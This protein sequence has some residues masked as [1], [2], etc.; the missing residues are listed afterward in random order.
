MADTL[1]IR[2]TSNDP[3][4]AR[5]LSGW[6]DD[7]RLNPPVSLTMDVAVLAA[8]PSEEDARAPF[9]QPMVEIRSGPPQGDVRIRWLGGS[10][11]ARIEATRATIQLTAAALANRDMLAQTFLTAVLVFLLRRSGWHHVHAAAARDPRGRNWLFAGNA[12]SGKSTTAA[13]LATHGWAVGADDLTF[14]SRG[15]DG[16]E[17]IAQRAPIAL[18]PAGH[19]LLALA[20]GTPSRGGR[21]TAYFPEE[22]GGSWAGRVTP[23]I[24]IFPRVEGGVTRIEPL[25]PREAL[26]ELV[27][28]SAWV[29]LEP[30]LAQGHLDLLGALARQTKAFRVALGPDL[31][32]EHDLM[33][34][35]VP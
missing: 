26:A 10:A 1:P 12:E 34:E 14:L 13:L 5:W 23:E 2:A 19:A 16:I 28:W 17:A 32:G 30:D 7:M 11:V 3:E 20:G 29:A 6:L 18:R 15:P 24:L 9:L 35:L 27:R 25:R 4:L 21:K 33:L 8:V 22:L 31:F